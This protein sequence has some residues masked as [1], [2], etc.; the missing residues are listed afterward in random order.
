MLN[1]PNSELIVVIQDLVGNDYK[2]GVQRQ[3]I[4][5]SL[6][7]PLFEFISHYFP[8][9]DRYT[10]RLSSAGD[11]LSK[12]ETIKA[13]EGRKL[14]WESFRFSL[15]RFTE[16]LLVSFFFLNISLSLPHILNK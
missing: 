12:D 10:A 13:K 2:S 7:H 14:F 8:K 4:G 3:G 11:P 1:L 5:R 9:A 6:V 15:K 16:S